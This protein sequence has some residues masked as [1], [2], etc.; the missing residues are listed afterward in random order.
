[1]AGFE[2]TDVDVEFEAHKLNIKISN[3]LSMFIANVTSIFAAEQ[4]KDDEGKV[5][6]IYIIS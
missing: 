5:T 2:V 6:V 1:M 4:L 3:E